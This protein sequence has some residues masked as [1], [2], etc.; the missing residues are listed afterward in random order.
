MAELFVE[1][2]VMRVK[3][4]KYEGMGR[5]KFRIAPRIGEYITTDED[6]I[7]QAYVVKAVMHP[8]E[9]AGTAGDIILSHVG[10]DLDLRKSLK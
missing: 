2:M 6:G 9:P 8:M 5:Q 10:S 4:G 7:G 3:D 1:F